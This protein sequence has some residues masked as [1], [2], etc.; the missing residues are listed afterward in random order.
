MRENVSRGLKPGQ[1]PHPQGWPPT[2]ASGLENAGWIRLGQGLRLSSRH[3]D[4]ADPGRSPAVTQALAEWLWVGMFSAPF[5]PV[6]STACSMTSPTAQS[7]T[8][9]I[10]RGCGGGGVHPLL[11][12]K[13]ASPMPQMWRFLLLPLTTASHGQGLRHSPPAQAHQGRREPAW[14]DQDRA[15]P[16]RGRQEASRRGSDWPPAHETCSS[17]RASDPRPGLELSCF[18][19]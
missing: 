9:E 10:P 2:Q 16:Q 14:Q 8:P 17:C 7:P 1:A 3:Q 13:V 18:P 4:Q 12:L 11:P 15:Q 6:F 19:V 5:K